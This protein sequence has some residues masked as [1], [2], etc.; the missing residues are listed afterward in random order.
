MME[1]IILAGGFGTR[2]R[3]V[4]NDVPKPMA[5]VAGRPFLEIV[6]RSLAKKGFNRVILSLG[7]KAE[8][9]RSHFGS[10]F[11]GVGIVYQVENTP[12]GTGGAIQASLPHCL[13]QHVH[14]INGDTY[15]DVD[16]EQVEAYW[17]ENC[18][19]VIVARTVEDTARYG[20]LRVQGERIVTFSEK[21]SSG[22]GLINAGWY[23]M[24]ISLLH[25]MAQTPPFSFETDFLAQA[26]LGY[27]FHVH[28]TI[29]N[30]I[31]IGIPKDYFLAQK[32]LRGL[33][34]GH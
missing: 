4:V 29:G 2:L 28:V 17:R 26:V 6:I 30:F 19:P 14:V 25:E 16:A 18:K 33:S 1:A 27:E 3:S 31:D 24:P 34:D 23:L 32:L 10:S 5:P 8:M 11:A 7:Y 13:G 9:I 21:G 12:L 20:A 22:S 15:L